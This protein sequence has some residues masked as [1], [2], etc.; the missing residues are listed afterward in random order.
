VVTEQGCEV[1]LCSVTG[2]DEGDRAAVIRRQWR[3]WP[4]P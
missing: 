1:Q 3:C 2:A 4:L